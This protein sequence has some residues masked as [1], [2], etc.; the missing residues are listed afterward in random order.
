MHIYTYIYYC[1]FYKHYQIC[2][3]PLAMNPS[4]ICIKELEQLRGHN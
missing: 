1:D 2:T 3:F 4:R